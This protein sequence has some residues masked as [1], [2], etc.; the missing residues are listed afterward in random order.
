MLSRNKINIAIIGAGAAATKIHIPCYLC[1]DFV[2]IGAVVDIDYEKAKKTARRF[3]IK[4]AFPSIK[5]LLD[6]LQVDAISICTPP[7]SH[8]DIAEEA[9]GRDIH[10]LCEKPLA[11]NVKNGLRIV[12]A[13]QD[14]TQVL[15]IDFNRRFYPCYQKA[16]GAIRKGVLG[17]VYLV[18]YCSMQPSPL[19]GWSKSPWFY[20]KGVGGSLLDQGPHVFDMLNW[21]L[22]KACTVCTQKIVHLDSEVNECCVT[23]IKY[24][25]DK[26]GVGLMSWMSSTSIEH[27]DVQGTGKSLLV[28][29]VF[30]IDFNPTDIP[31]FTLWRAA[32]SAV[33]KMA[34]E[35]FTEKRVNTYQLAI[36]HFIECIRCKKEPLINGYDGLEALYVT[37][38]ASESLRKMKSVHIKRENIGINT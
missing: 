12:K 38:A 4:H 3:R 30:S 8:A 31:Q 22:G 13:A 10:V 36:D 18:N 17:H 21:F 23:T 16:L 24:D 7:D 6:S 28:S 14:S 20:Q 1:N 34:K 29:P 33:S 11:D 15:M 35:S 19:L 37:E 5:S 25:G 27:L 32:A 2:N 9:M 26:L